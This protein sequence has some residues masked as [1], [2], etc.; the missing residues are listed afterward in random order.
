M[1]N[2]S[3]K[4]NFPSNNH[5]QII[6]I[7][8]SGVEMFK[9]TPIKSLAREIC[10]NS[11]D[12]RLDN[13]HPARLEFETFTINPKTIPD[14]SNLEDAFERSRDFWKIQDSTQARNFFKLALKD[15]NANTIK[16]LR[17]SD[18]NTSGLTGSRD[19]YNSPWCN[20]TKSS[21]AS[22][23]SGSNGGSFGIGKFAPFACSSLRTVFYS[24]YDVDNISASQGVARLTTFKNKK[25]ETTQG[26]GFY[27]CDKN[28]PMYN[29]Y[30]LNPNYTRP[31]KCTGT[32]IFIA[33]FTGET[34]WEH[35]MVAS[36]LDGFLYAIY[37][38]SL[39]VDVDGITI[40]KET[41]PDLMDSHKE[42]FKEHADEYYRV[43]TDN[44]NARSFTLELKDDPATSGT[45]TLR[46]MIEPTFNRRVAMIRQTGMK[47]KDKGN[48]NGIV[49]FAGTLLIEGD[50]INSYLRNLE[51]PQHLAWE[52][53]RADNKAQ[54]NQLMKTMLKF[55]KDS[56]NSM[57]DEIAEEELDPSVGEYLSANDAEDAANQERAESI[58]DEIKEIKVRVVEAPPKPSD[59]NIPDNKQTLVDAPDDEDGDATVTDLPGEGGSGSTGN[60]GGGGNGGGSNPGNGG[61]KT[62]VEHHKKFI[63]I[64]AARIRNVLRDKATGQYTI[65]FTPMISAQNGIMDV[66]MS[67]ESQNYEASIVSATCVSCPDLKVSN[68]RISNLVFTA[69]QPL[70]IDIQLDYHDYC[71]ME[72]K[73]YGNQV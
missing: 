35:Q 53:E 28:S 13:A 41:L 20:L 2:L 15:M 55:M 7:A 6:G 25:K 36:I 66:F 63:S 21:G 31:E 30:S 10:Q 22:N 16:C 60:G 8:D 65:V 62:P 57:K 39:V 26:I 72:V 44:E 64:S 3:P 12:A 24:T 69:N 73:A 67:A 70:R 4:W 9:G 11:L 58:T 43:L 68:N 29:Q 5:S 54:Y 17:I 56:L 59:A 52:K 42:Y 1:F 50:A 48:I 71:S 23:K 32:D 19:E 18:F 45:L 14:S 61:G 27:G 46:L 33:G 37:T 38:G 51:N 49:P 40:N 34:G 47:I